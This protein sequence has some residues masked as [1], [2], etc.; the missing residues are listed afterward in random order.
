MVHGILGCSVRPQKGT[1]LSGKVTAVFAKAAHLRAAD[2]FITLG[3][4]GLPSHPFSILTP[5]YPGQLRTGLE[6]L[7]TEQELRFSDGSV[8]PF[9]GMEEY[10]PAKGRASKARV[11]EIRTALAASR[12]WAGRQPFR[13]GFHGMLE[14]SPP[15]GEQWG[16]FLFDFGCRTTERFL[17][18]MQTKS[19]SRLAEASEEVAGLGEGLTPSGDDWLVGCLA[20]LHFHREHGGDGPPLEM[21]MDV[22]RQAGAKTS[23]FSGFLIQCSAKGLVSEPVSTWLAAAFEGRAQD[24]V[25]A[26]KAV[27]AFGHSSGMDCLAGLI[28]STETV[29]E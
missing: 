11:T 28:A 19:W 16:R 15:A 2:V 9:V 20:A 5:Y 29:L 13:G 6:F 21:L 26:A 17:R 23:A 12:D 24:A 22:A 1:A 27:A 18:V 3:T 7:I 25:H 10:V 4:L 8:I 14:A